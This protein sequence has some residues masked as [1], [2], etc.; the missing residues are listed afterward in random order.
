MR[1]RVLGP[2]CPRC[3]MVEENVKKAL[4]EL[5]VNA[6]VEKVTDFARMMEYGVMMTPALVIDN[7]IKCQGRIPSIEEIK[8]WIQ[9]V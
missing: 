5:G 6:E 8:E 3:K 2:G 9:G 4:D 1:I 7:E